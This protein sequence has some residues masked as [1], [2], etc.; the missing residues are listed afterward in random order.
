[1]ENLFEKI[2]E[3]LSPCKPKENKTIEKITT[4]SKK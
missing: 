3:P 4:K 1:M 2:S